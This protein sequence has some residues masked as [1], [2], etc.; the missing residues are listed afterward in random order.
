[1]TPPVGG[2]WPP[3][4]PTGGVGEE[5]ADRR[6]L[7]GRG[8]AGVTPGGELGH[9]PAYGPAIDVTDRRVSEAFAEVEELVEVSPI[10]SCGVRREA[11]FPDEPVQVVGDGRGRSA[12]P[13]RA[14][15]LLSVSRGL[16]L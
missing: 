15:V 10:G 9:E 14:R 12:L 7:A 4:R 2:W 3:T 13:R 16:T 8:A 5:G 6:C 1:M 11:S